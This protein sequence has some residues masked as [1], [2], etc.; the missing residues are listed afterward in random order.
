MC[1]TCLP[2]SEQRSGCLKSGMLVVN[3]GWSWY[4]RICIMG[5][6]LSEKCLNIVIGKGSS[7]EG[8]LHATTH[9]CCSSQI[10]DLTVNKSRSVT[11]CPEIELTPHHLY[12]YIQ[13]WYAFISNTGDRRHLCEFSMVCGESNWLHWHSLLQNLT[14]PDSKVHGAYMG[15]IWGRQDPGGPHVGPM[16]FAI[17]VHIYLYQ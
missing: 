2:L 5:V 11:R 15:P 16:S 14:Y 13:T 9:P 4:Q 12:I 6:A 3:R 17:W 7:N 10:H 1:L 8:I